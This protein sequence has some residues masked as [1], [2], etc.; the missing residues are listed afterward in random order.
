M[1]AFVAADGLLDFCPRVIG[2]IAFDK[3]NLVLLVPS[4]DNALRISSMFPA[5]L[6]AGTITETEGSLHAVGFSRACDH[7]I[8]HREKPEKGQRRDITI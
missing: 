4:S 6:R 8:E 1:S 7:D 5:S 2:G 3:D